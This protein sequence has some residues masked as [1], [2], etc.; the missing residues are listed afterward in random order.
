M[1]LTI[2]ILNIVAIN[3]TFFKR[4]MVPVG[5]LAL[6][7]N[8]PGPVVDVGGAHRGGNVSSAFGDTG[9]GVTG[10]HF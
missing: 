2:I 10:T 5:W 8:D 9:N 6:P 4:E 3:S 7:E 1:N